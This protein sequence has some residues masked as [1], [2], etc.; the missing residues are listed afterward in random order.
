MDAVASERST[1]EFGMML[2]IGNKVGTY[3]EKISLK[4]SKVVRCICG[5]R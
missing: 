1:D 3:F 5:S 4:S 2:V